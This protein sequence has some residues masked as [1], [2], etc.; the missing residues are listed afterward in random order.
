VLQGGAALGDRSGV[1]AFVGRRQ[2]HHIVTITTT[3]TYAPDKDGDRA[4]LAAIQ[5]D[6]SYLFFGIT[7]IGG[8]KMVALYT[9]EK[10]TAENPV[11]QAPLEGDGP[12]TLTLSTGGDSMRFEYAIKGIRH[13]LVSGV[14]ATFLSTRKAGGF[15]GTVIGPYAFKQ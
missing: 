7:E 13:E 4:G 12:V 9:R 2:Q 15:T 6:A 8:K 10:T 5:S 14:D 3:L 11:A 1:P